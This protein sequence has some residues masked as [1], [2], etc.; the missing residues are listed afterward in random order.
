[1]RKFIFHSNRT[2]IIIV[3]VICIYSFLAGC[4]M[5]ASTEKFSTKEGYLITISEEA[6]EQDTRWAKYLYDHLQK[7]AEDP[8]MVAYGVSE[9]DM[10]HIIVQIDPAQK[11]FKIERKENDIK[12]IASNSNQMLW[13]QYQLMKKISDED[14]RIEGSELPPAIINIKDTCGTFAFDYRSVYSPDGLNSDY[15]GVLGL[16]NFDEGW[17]IW[18]HNLRK[19]LGTNIEKFYATTNGK[20]NEE[21]LCFS[22]NEIYQQLESHIIDLHGEKGV[23][24][25]IAP[26]DHPTACTCASCTALG[27][28]A[29]NATPAVTQLIL[30]LAQRF[31]GHSFFTTSYLSTRKAPTEPLPSNVG[32]IVSAIDL[33][34]STKISNSSN[35]KQ[36]IQQLKEW[37]KVTSNIYVWDYTNNFDDYLSPFPI[38]SIAQ[39]RMRFFRDNG[40]NGVFFNGCG[41]SYSSFDEMRTFVLSALLISPDLSIEELTKAYFKQT[42]PESGELLYTY[43]NN[44]EKQVKSGKQLSIYAGVQEATKKYLDPNEFTKFYDEIGNFI[45]KTKGEERKKLNELLTALSFT[46][47]ELARVH[48][49]AP[50]GYATKEGNKVIARPEIGEWLNRLNEYKA[51]REMASYNESGDEIGKY[52]ENWEQYILSPKTLDNLLLGVKPTT[53]SA[54]DENYTDLSILTDGTHGLPSNYHFGWLINSTKEPIFNLPVKNMQFNGKLCLS[55][56]HMPRHRIYAPM[57]IELFKDGAT[58]KTVK[59]VPEKSDEKGQMV[60][61]EIP[62]ELK[63][64]QIVNVKITQSENSKSQIGIDEISLIP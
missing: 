5:H 24:F 14:G 13:V 60:K 33:P 49:F 22:S 1:M 54:L 61:V 62:V 40:I 29:T 38:L 56:L 36:F 2:S 64:T 27:N 35:E 30:R 18:G 32:V 59:V 47:L 19:V 23:H 41:Y 34:F 50:Y 8:E 21:Q 20:K 42:Y 25:V 58:Y 57:Q 28:T 31:P 55:F 9:K 4:G 44:L 37:K 45:K 10:W 43:Y 16:D 3:G 11:G 39:Q 63:E 53:D 12:L 15:T 17:G 46:R 48:P 52:I 7:R 6:T 51:F 26:D